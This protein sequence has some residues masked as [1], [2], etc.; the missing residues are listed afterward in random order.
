[1]ISVWW[2]LGAFVGGTWVGFLLM[3]LMQMS[4]NQPDPSLCVPDLDRPRPQPPEGARFRWYCEPGELV[5]HERS[6]Q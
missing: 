6:G 2:A 5:Q 1:M 3:A 4:A